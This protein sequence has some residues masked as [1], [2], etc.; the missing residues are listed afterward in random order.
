MW[1]MDWYHLFTILIIVVDN[2]LNVLI[3]NPVEV[4]EI[5]PR[6]HEIIDKFLLG[7]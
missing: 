1:S 2:L 6:L 7:F 5:L 3:R 4:N